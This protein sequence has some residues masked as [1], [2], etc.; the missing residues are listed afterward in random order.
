M[1][2]HYSEQVILKVLNA[3]NNQGELFLLLLLLF[4]HRND[5]VIRATRTF[6]LGMC[7]RMMLEEV[8][9]PVWDGKSH[10]IHVDYDSS[11]DCFNPSDL[12]MIIGRI[13]KSNSLIVN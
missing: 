4:T 2:N 1:Q 7:S 8:I 11:L 5:R 10:T 6:D 3:D 9:K 12:H 13:G